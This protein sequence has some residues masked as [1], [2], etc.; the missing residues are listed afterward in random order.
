MKWLKW[1]IAGALAVPLGHQI[2]FSAV[3]YRLMSRK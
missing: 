2:A 1:F 3:F